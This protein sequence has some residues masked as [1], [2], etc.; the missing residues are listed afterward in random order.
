MNGKF[1]FKRVK[2]YVKKA[3]EIVKILEDDGYEV[4]KFGNWIHKNK[5]NFIVTMFILC[6]NEIPIGSSI[7]GFTFLPEW[8]EEH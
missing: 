2:L 8:L 3:S 5:L 7:D 4:N 6:E 1:V